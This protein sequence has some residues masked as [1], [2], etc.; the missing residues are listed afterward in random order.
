[1][2]IIL[3]LPVWLLLSGC[4]PAPGHPLILEPI[5][6]FDEALK[7]SSGLI[8][9]QQGFISHNDSGNPAELFMLTPQGDISQRL[10]VPSPNHDWEAITMHEDTLYIG[11]IGN[12]GGRR[13]DLHI[14]KLQLADNKVE[15][16]AKLAISYS[17]QT[18]FQPPMHQHNFDAEALT[19]VDGELWLFTKRWLDANTTL[20]KVAPNPPLTSASPLTAQQQLAPAMLVTGADFDSHTHTL[21]LV[22]YSRNWLHR[23][24]WLWL[25]PIVQGQVLE[26]QGQQFKLSEQ[27]QF[28]GVSL[29]ADGHIYLTREGKGI[30]FFSHSTAVTCPTHFYS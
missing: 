19:W 25:Y 10:S 2:P 14:L 24:A 9:Y 6:H 3:L 11:D 8:A 29:G 21:M 20:Y 15:L 16:L 13:Q 30:N 1:M 7:E 28:E 22:G 5:T 17:E 23:H 26:E 18:R 12:N 27:G 4:Q